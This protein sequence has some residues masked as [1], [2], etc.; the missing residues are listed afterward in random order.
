MIPFSCC[1]IY[2]KVSHIFSYI[3]YYCFSRCSH[4]LYYPNPSAYSLNVR[5]LE[6]K[7]C[8]KDQSRKMAVPSAWGLETQLPPLNGATSLDRSM[9]LQN[10]VQSKWDFCKWCM[11]WNE[12]KWAQ[13]SLNKLKGAWMSLN[14]SKWVHMSLNERDPPESDWVESFP[15][16]PVPWALIIN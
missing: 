14:Q 9:R 1:C 13:V 2:A 8:S 6:L 16:N 7:R 11:S 12:L 15:A 10:D 5:E 4:Y 3:C